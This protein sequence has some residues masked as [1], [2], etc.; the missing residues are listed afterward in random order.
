[1]KFTIPPAARVIAAAGLALGAFGLFLMSR[2]SLHETVHLT[3][4]AI[5][6]EVAT[7][8]DREVDTLL[9]QFQIEPEWMRKSVVDIPN[10][11]A[12]RTER[13]IAI[14]AEILPVQMNVALNTLARRYNG[15]AI[16]YE[17]SK[18]HSV[19]INIEIQGCVLQNI[20]LK[21]TEHLIRHAKKSPLPKA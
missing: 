9:H 4:P 15:R 21:P 18:E 11:T 7:A 10:S 14:P 13:R 12:R 19:T 17:N 5:S 16:A 2:A 1:M 3:A 20:L 6:A 8:I